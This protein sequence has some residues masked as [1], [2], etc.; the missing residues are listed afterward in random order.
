M[1]EAFGGPTP[2]WVWPQAHEQRLA[3]LD[4]AIH[5]GDVSHAPHSESITALDAVAHP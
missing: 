4:M 5:F 3:K 2:A 1:N